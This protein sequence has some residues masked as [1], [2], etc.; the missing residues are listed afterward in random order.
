MSIL[1]TIIQKSAKLGALVDN[2]RHTPV[3]L[4]YQQLMELLRE[5]RYTAFGLEYGFHELMW[6]DDPIEAFKKAVPATDYNGIYEKWWSKSHLED[7]SDVC[8]PGVVPYYALSSGTSQSASKYIPITEDLLRGM[9][10]VSRRLF[11][12]LTNYG[13]PASQYTK[14]MLMI[15]SSTQLQRQGN[16]W[17]GDLSGILGLNRPFIM[18]RL[19][20]PGRHIT[21]LT[22]WGDRIEKIADEAPG[23]DVGFA[24]GN[25]MWLQLMLER[26]V[27]KHGVKN[28][29]E[30]WP[31]FS[32]FVHGGVLIDPYIPSLAGLFREPILYLDSYTASEG[33][34]AYQQHPENRSMKL[35]TDSGIFFEFVPF[36]DKN[37]NED[38][39]LRSEQPESLRLDEVK[40][41]VHY[42]LLLNTVAGV[43]RYLLGDTIQFTNVENAEI[44]VTGRTKQFLSA[45]GEHVSIDNLSAAV[46]AVDEQLRAGVGEFSVAAVR[47][48]TGWAHQWFVSL[49]N[50]AV[51]E[52]EFVRVIDA[53]LSRLNDDYAV[54]RR[55]ALRQVRAKFLPNE[56]FMNWLSKRGKMNGQAKVP[57]VLKGVQLADFEEFIK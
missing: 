13:I 15:G 3:E 16:H 34:F 27:D 25:P 57:R 21:D 14:Q 35:M 8:W 51:T 50:P 48:G 19:Y 1:G 41:G 49:E 36:N 17:F 11:F 55:Y 26:I 44:R 40:E 10:K 12:D 2:P 32:L 28:I 5:A 52:E 39:D 56:V 23:W 7:A 9:K 24:A 33:F 6:A 43:W 37:F 54:E 31:N 38:G 30:L 29:H 45:C 42:A 22:E 20:R 46:R 4:Q 18:E 47:E 53:E